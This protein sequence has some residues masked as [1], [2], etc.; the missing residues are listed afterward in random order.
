MAN[1]TKNG[2]PSLATVQP[3]YEHQHNNLVAGEALVAGDFVYIHSGGTVRKANGT[4]A[5]AA[6]KY[7]GVVLQ[8]AEIGDGVS[9]HQG[10]TIHY[11]SGLTP[12]ARYY[13]AT[14]AGL[15]SDAPT[16]GGDVPCAKAIDA[17][18]IYVIPPTR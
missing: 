10:V 5:N 7:D 15:L 3:G 1:L 6:A 14:T 13:L 8:A 17:T 16:T 11:G 2:R 12:G 9:V 4:A 18:R